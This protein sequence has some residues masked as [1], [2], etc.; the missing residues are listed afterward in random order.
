MRHRLRRVLRVL[1]ALTTPL[2][3]YEATDPGRMTLEEF[4]R[5]RN[6]K[7]KHHPSDAYDFD[8]L[9]LNRDLETVTTTGDV[10]IQRSASSPDSGYVFSRGDVVVGVYVN[11]TLYADRFLAKHIPKGFS[12]RSRRG[13][14]YVRL[15]VKKTQEV[16]Y[17]SDYVYLV[18]DVAKKNRSRYPELLQ[19]LKVKNEVYE[20]RS[21]R[22]PEKNAGTTLV[23][24][25]SEGLVVAQA[26][27]EWGTTLIAVVKEYRG[28]GLGVAIGKVW[29][30]YNP[31]YSSGGFTNAG[32]ANAVRIW[33]DRVREYMRNGWY[34]QL[35]RNGDV[36][37]KQVQ[38]ITKSLPGRQ[39]EE[40]EAPE[41]V[42]PQVL[43][44]VDEDNISFIVYDSRFL[45]DPDEKWI[46]AYGFFRDSSGVGTYLYRIEYDRPYQK[47]ANSIALQMARDEG[48]R[49]Y[50]GGTPGDI[51]ETQGID[52]VVEEDGY[53]SLD[54]DILNL[55]SLRAQEKRA[56]TPY[57]K[58]QEVS[59]SLVELAESKWT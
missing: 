42:K 32:K 35:V 51:M 47:L 50:V 3:E 29:Y 59:H 4:L 10:T 11:G 18:S 23:L 24:L 45:T 5:H 55:K 2:P 41:P 27:D 57:D 7:G 6:P 56:R 14:D 15:E 38:E 8:L 19:R 22:K 13:D 49:I 30:Q 25:N 20:L 28:K 1:T 26:S 53:V 12:D 40:S 17:P 46:L 58:Y 54:A 16:K 31:E 52:H 21:E 44:K 34:S 37:T 43:V 39:K 33:A 48:E 9:T 36:T